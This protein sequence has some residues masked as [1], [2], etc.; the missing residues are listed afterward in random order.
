M[1]PVKKTYAAIT[2]YNFSTK[3]GTP[4]ADEQ[5]AVQKT[6]ASR[7]ISFRMYEVSSVMIGGKELKGEPEN[8]SASCW[9]GI[10]RIYTRDEVIQSMRDDMKH[11]DQFMK[12]AIAS[13]IEHYEQM[14]P[15]SVHITGLERQGEFIGIGQDQKV[16]DREG[17]QSGRSPRP[18]SS[19]RM[20][21]SP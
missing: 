21:S 14:S 4:V 17:Q 19:W 12:S 9:V 5:D 20:T 3:M 13:V 18:A 2:D 8:Y 6:L 11:A 10:D 7:G 15:D 1:D 16:F